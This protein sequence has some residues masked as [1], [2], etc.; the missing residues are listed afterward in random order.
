LRLHK[1]Y[2][3]AIG[4]AAV[5]FEGANE[6]AVVE[7]TGVTTDVGSR[8]I[9]IIANLYFLAVATSAKVTLK[10]RRGAGIAG[11]VVG[12]VSLNPVV[13]V[14]NEVTLTC[15]DVVGETAN[16]TY[17]V[18]ALEEKAGA[19]DKSEFSRLRVEY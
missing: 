15:K 3:E 8:E 6:V 7:F 12:E 10:V 13:S 16:G 5:D 17:T 19:K 4:G 9:F 1:L 18:T 2:G 11:A 14:K